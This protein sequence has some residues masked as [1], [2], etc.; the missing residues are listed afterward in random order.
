VSGRQRYRSGAGRPNGLP[1]GVNDPGFTGFHRVEY[2]LW[3]NQ[4]VTS[5]ISVTSRLDG[6]VHGLQQAFPVGGGY[7]FVPP[8]V[9]DEGDY[10]ASGLI[11][12]T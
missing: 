11:A 1:E 4:S 7:F 3:H 10:Y 2:A 12:A 8:G 5:L 6:Y 9:A